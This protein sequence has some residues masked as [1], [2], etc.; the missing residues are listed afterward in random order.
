MSE[1]HTLPLDGNYLLTLRNDRRGAARIRAEPGQ[2]VQEGSPWLSD[3][4][5]FLREQEDC[6][7][8]SS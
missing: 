1:L 7:C 2:L 8:Q 6:Y 4:A 5:A 3:Y